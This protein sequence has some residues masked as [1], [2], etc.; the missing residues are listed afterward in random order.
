MTALGDFSEDHTAWALNKRSTFE[1]AGDI[2]TISYNE[3]T[4]TDWD[5]LDDGKYRDSNT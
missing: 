1:Q 2:A 4:M 3:A 5:S